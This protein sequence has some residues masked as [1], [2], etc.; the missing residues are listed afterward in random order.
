M[1]SQIENLQRP[2]VRV[3]VATSVMLTF[4]SFWRA[5]AIVLSDLASSAYYVGGDAEK[6]IGKSAPW[7]VL[8]VMLFSYAVRAIYI[9]SSSM[10]VRGGVYRVVKEAMGGKLAKLSV[11]ALLFDYVLTGPI[12]AVSAGLYLSGLLTDTFHHF[13]YN[14]TVPDNAFAAFFAILVTIYFWWQNVQGIHES[15]ERAMQIMKITTVMVVMLIVW[16]L[17]TLFKH[18]APLPPLPSPVSMHHD[19]EALGWLWHTWAARIP[20]IMLLVGFGHSVLAMS[21]EESLAQINREIEHPKL[22]NLERTGLVIFIYSLLFTSLVSFFAVMIIPDKTRPDY[23]ANLIGGLAMNV[24]GPYTLRLLFQAFVVVVGALILSGAVNTAIVGAN[25]VLNRMSEDGV[26]TPWFRKPHHRFGTSYRIIN[27]IVGL[28]ILTIVASRGNVYLLASLYAFGVIWSFA[29]KSLAVVVLRYTEPENR[30][31]KVPGNL[32]IAGVEIPVGLFLI[33]LLLFAT[34]VVNLFTKQ[35]ATISG[36][37]FSV[38][39]FAIFTVSEHITSKQ[40]AHEESGL[41]QFNVAQNPELSAEAMEVRPGNVLVAVRDPRNLYYLERVLAKTNTSKTDVVVMTSRVYHREH[42]FSGNEQLDSSE[43]FRKYEQELF[44]SV[45]AVAEKLGKHVSLLVVPTND[46]FE[47]IVATAQRLHSSVILCGKSNKLTA[48]E[49]GKL[50]G[51][52]WERLPEP[53]PRLR[54]VV[55]EPDGTKHEYMLGPHTPR[56]R[57]E[58]VDLLHGLWKEVTADPR[59]RELHHYHVLNVALQEMK[60]R[61]HDNER[62]DDVM[63]DIYNEMNRNSDEPIAEDGAQQGPPT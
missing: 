47:S 56:M 48:D 26:L 23:F 59:Y 19:K 58:D 62:K 41:D 15:S 18:P 2:A 31:W 16:C 12:S 22:K 40:H 7:F 25:G 44:T 29:F 34:A 36:V 55:Y 50:T 46:I 32:H 1:S 14:I 9:E 11:S 53:R 6:V 52:A 61:M 10:F 8:A 49:Q 24:V 20:F 30:Q 39:F 17:I 45:V 54:L 27:L 38:A 57:R 35:L 4:I 63:N 3:F 37:A 28:Q 51:D 43:V 60:S 5:A 33:S 42:S 21:G 13:G